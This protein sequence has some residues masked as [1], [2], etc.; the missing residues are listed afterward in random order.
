[1]IARSCLLVAVVAVCC[2]TSR[3]VTAEDDPEIFISSVR[4]SKENELVWVIKH[5]RFMAVPVWHVG[6]EQP[7]LS[8][9]RRDG[10][11]SDCSREA[12]GNGTYKMK[13]SSN[14]SLEPTALWRCAS[15]PILISVVSTG[16]QPRS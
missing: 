16:A 12:A 8:R 1:M 3:T 10:R 14:Q 13:K 15:K 6:T 2:A 11:Q 7:A 9:Q 4:L 5:S